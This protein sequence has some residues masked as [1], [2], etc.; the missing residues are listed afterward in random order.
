MP[1]KKRIRPPHKGKVSAAGL[2]SLA[3]GERPY[4]VT[5]REDRTP[6][7]RILFDFT[8]HGRRQQPATGIRTVRQADGQFDPDAI[9]LAEE[10]ADDRSARLR[11]ERYREEVKPQRLTVMEALTLYMHPERG[12]VAS[13]KSSRMQ[14]AAARK[15]WLNHLG[16]DT[17]WNMVRPADVDALARSYRRRGML[18]T[19]RQRVKWLR[20]VFR[21]LEIKAGIDGLKDP[22]RG[23]DYQALMEGY[24]PHRPRY[25]PDEVEKIL[26]V[27]WEIDPRFALLTALMDDSG[28]R[29]AALI[30]TW[31]SAIDRRR[32]IAPTP[33]LAPH[34]WILFPALKGQDTVLHFLTEFE[35]RE[36]DMALTTHL[37]ELERRYQERGIDY[38]L[39][40][41]ARIYPRAK[42]E[43]LPIP[44]DRAGAY[45][46]VGYT[47]TERWLR[48]AEAKAKVDHVDGRLW[49]GWRRLAADTVFREAGLGVVT[50][51][52]GWKS[53]RTPEQ[54]YLEDEKHFARSAAREAMERKRKGTEK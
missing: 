21:W 5:V 24:E 11:L 9:N 6:G 34:G 19:A 10:A 29:R 26:A 40:P 49:H 38:P 15:D 28:T 8:E 36:I 3:K 32:D 51:A 41:A 22:T 35:R 45:R 16:A 12:G 31:R 1:R 39:F 42:R 33:E 27:R 52:M 50:T 2:W 17:V 25:T 53:Q 14:A 20:T 43:R 46:P 13:S 30:R 7:G 23:F 18:V 48:D 4:T 37:S 47:L 44:W 54:I